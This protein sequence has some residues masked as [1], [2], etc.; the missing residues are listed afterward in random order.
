[1]LNFSNPSRSYD[2]VGRGVHFWGYDR[3]FEISF[4]VEE[5]ALSAL[6]PSTVATESGFLGT[7]DAHRERINKAATDIYSRRRKGS[8]I[9]AYTLRKSD[10]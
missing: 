2:E 4:F 9:Y 3:T 7:F 1:V 6:S 5:D 10:C 8:Y